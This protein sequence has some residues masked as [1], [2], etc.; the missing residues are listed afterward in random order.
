VVEKILFVDDEPC[1]LEGY[2]RLL[3]REFHVNVALGGEQGLAAIQAH[4]PYAVVISD[5][6][7]PG[8][9]G[10][11]FLAQVREKA[12][13]T[14]RMLLTGHSDLNAAIDAVNKGNILRFLSKPC[15]KE[16]LVE[17]INFGIAQYRSS[18]SE[19]DLVRKAQV[20]ERAA[21]I[22]KGKE[23]CQWDNFEGPTGLPGPSQAREYLLPLFKKD[24]QCYVILLKFTALRILEERYGEEA[25]G[26]YLNVEAQSL[27]QALRS[28]DRLFHWGRDV[29]MAV[30]RRQLSLPAVRMEIMRLT[31]RSHEHTIE[32]DGRKIMVT[33]T[34]SF[35]LL[36][37]AQFMSLDDM[38]LSLDP[39]LTS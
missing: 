37:V 13:E 8:M 11:E 1:V 18:T 17:A 12:P 23:T 14:V 7:M 27:M 28:D 15:E 9:N 39:I 4:G 2:E 30:I 6:R 20:L 16:V 31:S 29:L 10:A 24:R 3:R 34:T 33:N 25:F 21:S 32:V 5:M 36:P 26:D 38:L 22:R 35:D 19:K